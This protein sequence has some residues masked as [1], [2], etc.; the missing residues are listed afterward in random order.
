MKEIVNPKTIKKY[1]GRLKILEENRIDLDKCKISDIDDFFE[2]E[3]M[4]IGTRINYLNAILYKM[5]D[6]K[7]HGMENFKNVIRNR[8]INYHGEN[9]KNTNKKTLSEREKKSFVDWSIILKLYDHM[10]KYCEMHDNIY[11]YEL[12]LILSLYIKIPTRR[13]IDYVLMCYDNS[14]IINVNEVIDLTQIYNDEYIRNFDWIYRDNEYDSDNDISNVNMN[15]NEK[16]YYVKSRNGSFFVFMN[17]K[18]KGSH[19]RQVF[20]LGDD[21]IKIIDRYIELKKIVVGGRLFEPRKN[22]KNN[23]ETNSTTFFTSKIIN[24][25]DTTISKQITVTSLRHIYIKWF[26]KNNPSSMQMRMVS[27]CMAHDMETQNKYEKIGDFES[28]SDLNLGRGFETFVK[29]IENNTVADNNNLCDYETNLS[30]I[31]GFLLRLDNCL[32]SLKIQKR[33]GIIYKICEDDKI[34]YIGSTFD[35]DNRFDKHLK[36]NDRRNDKLHQYMKMNV[37][38]M[39]MYI[40]DKINVSSRLE[41]ELWEDYYIYKFKMID[42]GKNMKYNTSIFIDLISNR[43]DYGK[44]YSLMGDFIEKYSCERILY[45]DFFKSQSDSLKLF[46]DNEISIKNE[47]W[48]EKDGIVYCDKNIIFN[49]SCSY[50]PIKRLVIADDYNDEELFGLYVMYWERT[51]VI[52]YR[53]NGLRGLAK[54]INEFG[55]FNKMNII[56]EIIKNGCD[57]KIIPV[58]YARTKINTE[59]ICNEFDIMKRHVNKIIK[60]NIEYGMNVENSIRIYLFENTTNVEKFINLKNKNL[61]NILKVGECITEIDNIKNVRE[62]NEYMNFVKRYERNKIKKQNVETIENNKDENMNKLEH[63]EFTEPL[64]EDIDIQKDGD[65]NIQIYEKRGRPKKYITEDEVNKAK[66]LARQKWYN[67]KGKNRV[68]EYN[69]QYY[70]KLKKNKNN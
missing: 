57:F 35:F 11:M 47:L 61:R 13:V 3:K 18:T 44:K 59:K 33:E 28:V 66:I 2:V 46:V 34:L 17:Y 23:D 63:I 31:N 24:F 50:D 10:A 22:S 37:N 30:F 38:T 4:A 32:L 62:M 41:L 43:I 60:H 54:K 40:I 52:F 25:F 7:Y 1:N 49:N 5:R 14:I 12:Y 70:D 42:V 15:N 16:N 9:I 39:K 48:K 19:G 51:F 20:K 65:K 56:D 6:E 68:K 58:M 8:I 69:R 67:E 26:L 64:E 29:I 21:I 45:E 27:R 53:Q 36:Q 55:T